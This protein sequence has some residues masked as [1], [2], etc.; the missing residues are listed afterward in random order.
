M[1]ASR[2]PHFTEPEPPAIDLWDAKALAEA[3][4]RAAFPRQAVQLEPAG[5][6]ALWQI[7]VGVSPAPV[8]RVVEL[9]LDRPAWAAPAF[10]VEL[11]LGVM[12]SGDV[13]AAGAHAHGAGA[14]RPSSPFAGVRFTP[15]PS[16]PA[17]SF[18]LALLLPLDMPASRVEAVLRD[19][20]GDLL[21]SLVLFDEFRGE[22]LPAGLR[23]VGW[24]LTFRHPERTLRDKEIDGR[25]SGLLKT[26]DRELGVRPRT[27]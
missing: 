6:A 4:A 9:A 8:G 18:D 20:A 3:I 19:S 25:R 1:G 15:L 17:A 5:D 22:G 12:P 2:P 24:R 11:T 7:L 26:L 21:E 16:F 23:S 13:A 10:G 14:S 27:S